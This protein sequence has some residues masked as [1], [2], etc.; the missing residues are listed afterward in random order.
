MISDIS[1]IKYCGNHDGKFSLPRESS[2]HPAE[3]RAR[4]GAAKEVAHASSAW[5]SYG[6][7][8]SAGAGLCEVKGGTKHPE[9][10][11]LESDESRLGG[12]YSMQYILKL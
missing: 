6:T 8:T 10:M 3:G 9:Q 11:V 7:R 4:W 12:R 1:E 2:T 5:K